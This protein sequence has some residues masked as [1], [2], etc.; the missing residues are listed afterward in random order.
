[1]F[2]ALLWPKQYH[3]SV[4]RLLCFERHFGDTVWSQR[5]RRWVR[6][7]GATEISGIQYSSTFP[8]YTLRLKFILW[9]QTEVGVNL[10][11][12][13]VFSIG[14]SLS[15]LQGTLIRVQLCG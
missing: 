5:R 3:H 12:N 15:E 11:D 10:R 1:V 6:S 14:P 7:F 13:T 8:T 9:G 4:P 2:D